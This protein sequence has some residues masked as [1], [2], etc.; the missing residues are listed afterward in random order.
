MLYFKKKQILMI[1]GG[2]V[3]NPT[4]EIFYTKID[5]NKYNHKWIYFNTKLPIPVC[6]LHLDLLLYFIIQI[7]YSLWILMI[8]NGLIVI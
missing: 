4:D 8:K 5:H 6:V 2:Y 7:N 3:D 1:F